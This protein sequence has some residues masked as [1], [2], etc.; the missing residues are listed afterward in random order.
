MRPAAA[1]EDLAQKTG[2]RVARAYG[3]TQLPIDP[4]AIAAAEQIEISALPAGEGGVSGVFLMSG[5]QA[6]I[7]YRASP[8]HPGFERFSVAHELGHYFIEG[9]PEMILSG[10]G[11]HESR[12]G[13]RG[14]RSA[15]EVEADHFAAALLMPPPAVQAVLARAPIGLEAVRRLKA[16][17]IVSMTAA[18]IACARH[19]AHP[20]AI[21]VSRG[22]A[23]DYAFL[24]PGFRRLGRLIFPRKG[25]PL[26]AGATAS[27]NLDAAKVRKAATATGHCRIGD[28]FDI[29][30]DIDLDE[31]IIGLGRSGRT[32]T[33]LSSEDLP[34]E[35]LFGSEP[36]G[37]DQP[38]SPR[39]R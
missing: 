15:V 14:T 9:H 4:F 31:E 7:L 3:M 13:F 5:L 33:V 29:D 1:R 39:F 37:S 25:D 18:A 28:W 26:P 34:A 19:A 6:A 21:I 11:R 17:A 36:P 24:S 20:M 2:E 22:Q 10:G 23:V 38:W 12:A 30:R 8:R 35:D 32:L 16:E 27:F